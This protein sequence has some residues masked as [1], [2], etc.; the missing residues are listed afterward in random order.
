MS[1][2]S[3]DARCYALLRTIPRGR[4]STYKLLAEALGTQAW[5]AVGRAMAR[6]PDLVQTPCHRIVRSDGSLGGYAQGVEAKISLLESEGIRIEQ[7]KIADLE[8]VLYR[9]G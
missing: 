7:G 5:R 6:N 4:V 9:F 2:D 8:A 1:T 3:F